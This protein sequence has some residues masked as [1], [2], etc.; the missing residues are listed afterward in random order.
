MGQARETGMQCLEQERA[1]PNARST[2]NFN[3]TV[4]DPPMRNAV[5]QKRADQALGSKERGK[6]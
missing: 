6:G 2:K 3:H 5:N 4:G 1:S